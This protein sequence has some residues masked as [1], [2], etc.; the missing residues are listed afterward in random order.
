M[1]QYFPF[2]PLLEREAALAD[3]DVAL[4]AARRG[5]GRVALVSGGAGM[6]KTALVR[7][8]LAGLD[9][10]VAVREGACDD[11]LTPRPLG[12]VFDLSRQAGPALARA[13]AAGRPAVV[14]VMLEGLAAPIFGAGG[15]H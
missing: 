10:G 12:P 6:G 4:A 1:P 9:A 11:L 7:A 3:L 13:L 5:R 8:F 14:N 15:A 2:M